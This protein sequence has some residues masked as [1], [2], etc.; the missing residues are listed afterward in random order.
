MSEELNDELIRAKELAARLKESIK[1]V[2]TLIR[3][4][5]EV[6]PQKKPPEISPKSS[7]SPTDKTNP[8]N[9]TSAV[10][11]THLTLPTILLV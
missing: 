4:S 1:N 2:E 9:T 7:V 8:Q 5:K 10:S 6:P 3:A 11:Y